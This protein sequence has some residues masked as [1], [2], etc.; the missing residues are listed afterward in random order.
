MFSES[1]NHEEMDRFLNPVPLSSERDHYLNVLVTCSTVP[2]LTVLTRIRE[3]IIAG[4]H[5]HGQRE[6]LRPW[7][8]DISETLFSKWWV[9]QFGGNDDTESSVAFLFHGFD[10]GREWRWHSA[11]VIDHSRIQ[12]QLWVSAFPVSG[13]DSLRAAFLL[14][15][16]DS[17]EQELQ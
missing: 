17:V 4:I 9:K 2:A 14:L 7:D 11:E 5:I 13:F 3:V 12:L 1:D 6:M 10:T 16:A 15:G 8:D